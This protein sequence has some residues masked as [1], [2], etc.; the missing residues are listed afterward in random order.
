M[1]DGELFAAPQ[2]TPPRLTVARQ[3]A[4]RAELAYTEAERYDEEGDGFGIIPDEIK[5]ELRDARRE[6][7]SAECEEMK[8]SGR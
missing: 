5:K 8:R 7:A 1:N 6:L 4:E 2:S 3:R